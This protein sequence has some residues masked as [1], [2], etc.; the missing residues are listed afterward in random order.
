LYFHR[1]S[2]KPQ[3]AFLVPIIISQIKH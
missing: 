1:S 3:A 2:S